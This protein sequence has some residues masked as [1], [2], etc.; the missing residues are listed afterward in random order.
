M[1]VSRYPYLVSY[2][3]A[4][5]RVLDPG[6][7]YSDRTAAPQDFWAK[8]NSI[9]CP[10]GQSPGA[11]Y[12]VVS[13][14][15]N[16]TL[17]MNETYSIKWVHEN[18]TTTWQNYV[19]ARIWMVG[20]DGDGQ[21]AALVELL[22]KRQLMRGA[23]SFSYNVRRHGG[24]TWSSGS[25]SQFYSDSLDS[26]ALFTWQAVLNDL[27]LHFPSTL[28]GTAP[29]LPYIPQMRLE[30]FHNWGDA[31]EAVGRL[32]AMCQCRLVLDPVADTFTVVRIGGVQS[33][34][35]AQVAA[36]AARVMYDATPRQ[37][38]Q[39]ASMPETIRFYFPKYGIP[40]QTDAGG[41]TV[42]PYYWINKPTNL[43]G[44]QAGTVMPYMTSFH[45]VYNN[46]SQADMQNY[47]PANDTDLQN[48]AAELAE[49]VANKI[50]LGGER[51][52]IIWSGI[53]P[54]TALS[55]GSEVANI[56][57]R[58][59]GGDEGC[60]TDAR[61]AEGLPDGQAPPI[62]R[63]PRPEDYDHC[64]A[65]WTSATLSP[66]PLTPDLV[67]SGRNGTVV[68]P[69]IAAG[70]LAPDPSD[71]S[72]F[73]ALS[74]TKTLY[75]PLPFTFV[76]GVGPDD[77]WC[78][79]FGDGKFLLRGPTG[80]H[81]IGGSLPT[82][83]TTLSGG[84]IQ[85]A[86]G[87]SDGTG[88]GA[89]GPF[90][91]RVFEVDSGT[92][93]D[94]TITATGPCAY[95]VSYE[96]TVSGVVGAI[97]GEGRVGSSITVAGTVAQIIG[98]GTEEMVGVAGTTYTQQLQGQGILQADYGNTIKVSCFSVFGVSVVSV[99]GRI[100]LEAILAR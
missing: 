53:V 18:G 57:W 23:N 51:G 87:N 7:L 20:V 26:S 71:N 93:T 64:L 32:L 50:D 36:L 47:A 42:R 97:A 67:L 8:A 38:L 68:M 55:L 3:G 25:V 29:T 49:K 85:W 84:F 41:Q 92:P 60:V 91:G 56:C 39:L 28:R 96:V 61:T 34:L 66:C 10:T 83:G 80:R 33:G 22:D 16:D 30:N 6:K 100:T 69:S 58:D 1:S 72:K 75:N 13:R 37:N 40:N 35:A 46:Q 24:G 21:S 70:V 31:W 17:G 94:I 2:S 74:G 76:S 9:F 43:A 4:T 14:A 81:I 63:E 48:L 86:T 88:A 62:D 79:H 77:Y 5:F 44:A 95:R 12:F 65:Y 15:V 59:Y 52:R 11:A 82:T 45:A 99:T 89:S 54:T 78:S 90:V 98:G 19:I 27:W 73:L